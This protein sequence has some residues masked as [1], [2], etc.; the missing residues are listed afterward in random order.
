MRLV[1]LTASR[2]F[3]GPERQ[4]IG[5][6]QALPA[7]CETVFASFAEG[8]RCEAF[9]QQVRSQDF[10]GLRLRHDTPRL[11]AARRELTRLLRDLR[12]DVL[13]CHGYKADLIGRPAARRAGVPVVAVS[14]GWTGEDFKVRCYDRLDRLLLHKMDRV[15]CVSEGQARKVR[16]AGVPAGRVR[17]IRNSARADAFRQPDPA[18]RRQIEGLFP[19]PGERIVL[20]AGRLSPDKGFH[21]LIE[22]AQSVVRADPGARFVVCG[23]GPSRADLEGQV[24]AAGLGGGVAFAGFRTDLDLW[25]PNADLF[26]LPSFREGLPNVV[27]EACASAVPVVAT[28]VGGTAEVLLDG[29]TGYVVPPGDPAA[30][31]DRI[32]RLLADPGLRRRMGDAGRALVGEQFTFAAQAGGYLEL[33]AEL[34][35]ATAW[36][37]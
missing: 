36:A 3:G 19:R 27:L 7:D 22:A 13:L 25:M 30:L 32:G 21:V 20:A 12:A 35:P 18:V 6:A 23:D 5:L 14:R 9:L 29:Q 33:F 28:D 37:A 31:A 17:V 2:F 15:V 10:I 16:A 4:M 24:R 8:G 11:F 26:V 1:H 34:A